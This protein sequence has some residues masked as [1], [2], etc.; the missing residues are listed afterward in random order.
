MTGTA[1][2]PLIIGFISDLMF[3]VRIEDVA[4]HLNFEVKWIERAEQVAPPDP[5]AP[6]RQLA[7]HLIGPGAVLLD[8]LTF[9]KPALLIFDLGN[10]EIP[11]RAWIALIKSV[12]ATRRIPVLCYGSHVDGDTLKAAQGAGADKVLARSRFVSDLPELIQKYARIPDYLALEEVCHLPLSNFA[13]K[14]LEL[15]NHGE[16]FEAHEYLESAWNEDETVGKE[17][18][19]AILQVAVAYLQI[20]R[21]NYNGAM[22]MFLRMRQWIDPLPD[23][24]RGVNIAQLRADAYKAR[25]VMVTLGRERI[26]EFDRRL[27]RPVIYQQQVG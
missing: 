9:L 16:Y 10:Q 5:L 1:P 20:E 23:V 24:C 13:L 14:G 25:E 7:E 19:R 27:L 17:L 22:K 18:Y 12:P 21:G 15:F 6:T 8:Q 11:W 3:A 4:R 26:R 2:T